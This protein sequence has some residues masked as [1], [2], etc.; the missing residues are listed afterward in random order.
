MA[1]GPTGGLGA[2]W[3]PRRHVGGILL[4]DASDCIPLS[5]KL[6]IDQAASLIINP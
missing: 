1:R 6:P 4:A 3:R 5:P 2:G